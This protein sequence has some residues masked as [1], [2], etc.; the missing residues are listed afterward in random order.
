MLEVFD[1]IKEIWKTITSINKRL[2][3]LEKIHTKGPHPGFI[4]P[5]CG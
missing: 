4:C 3:A 2:E 5:S 1:K